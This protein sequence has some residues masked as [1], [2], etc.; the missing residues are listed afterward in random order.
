[1]IKSDY[2][3]FN[4]LFKKKYGAVEYVP[5]ANKKNQEPIDKIDQICNTWTLLFMENNMQNQKLL[6]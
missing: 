4:F 3:L 5:N 6:L 1:M 2:K